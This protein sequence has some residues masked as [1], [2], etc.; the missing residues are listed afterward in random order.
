MT[1]HDTLQCVHEPFGDAYYFGPE[2]LAERYE[3]D[4]KARKESGYEESTF[5]TIFDRIARE[6]SEVRLL[7]FLLLSLSP[8]SI[9]HSLS[10]TGHFRRHLC[11]VSLG[12]PRPIPSRSTTPIGPNVHSWLHRAR[13]QPFDLPG[14]TSPKSSL[15]PT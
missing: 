11:R 2:R 8:H 1:R 10:H 12:P 5:R 15:S 3:N 14:T 6:N 13:Y 7:M 9:Q 4:P